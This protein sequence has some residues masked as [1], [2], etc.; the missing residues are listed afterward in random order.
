M[1]ADSPWFDPVGHAGERAL[2]RWAG[3][4][5]DWTGYA[6]GYRRAFERLVDSVGTAGG[7]DTLVFPIVWLSRHAIEVSLKALIV[8]FHEE[9]GEANHLEHKHNLV[10]LRHVAEESLR[11]LWTTTD[12]NQLSVTRQAI[13]EISELDPD[14]TGFRYPE[15]RD[16]T[17]T[18]TAEAI[19]LD[20]VAGVVREVLAALDAERALVLAEGEWAREEAMREAAMEWW[21]GLSEDEREEYEALDERISEAWIEGYLD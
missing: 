13:A 6:I 9:L 18:T 7:H 17:A 8:S 3:H 12:E 5:P 11:R 10:R 4:K 1:K 21:S 14:G 15:R 19:N 20:V 2:L 16:G